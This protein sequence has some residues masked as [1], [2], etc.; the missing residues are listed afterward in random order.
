MA[1]SELGFD[2]GVE[3]YALRLESTFGPL[4]GMS[5]H[6]RV[7]RWFNFKM[8]AARVD[9]YSS[10]GA[11]WMTPEDLAPYYAAARDKWVKR[12]NEA[13][14]RGDDNFDHIC[15]FKSKRKLSVG[16]GGKCDHVD[17]GECTSNPVSITTYKAI[18]NAVTVIVPSCANYSGYCFA[19]RGSVNCQFLECMCGTGWVPCHGCGIF[20][21]ARQRCLRGHD[22]IYPLEA[23]PIFMMQED[24]QAS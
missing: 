1:L 23:K 12:L 10:T 5:A 13:A 14:K 7:L 9:A 22:V 20:V 3:T 4:E 8:T 19:C 18:A 11:R 15:A 2:Q 17:T 24:K 21:S 6:G 16:S